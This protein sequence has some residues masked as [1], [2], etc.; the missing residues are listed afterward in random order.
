V[1][2]ICTKVGLQKVTLPFGD[3]EIFNTTWKYLDLEPILKR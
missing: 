3:K 1:N 2:I